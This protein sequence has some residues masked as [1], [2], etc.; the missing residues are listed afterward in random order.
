MRR[1]A[2]GGSAAALGFATAV[3][4]TVGAYPYLINPIVLFACQLLFTAWFIVVGWKLFRTDGEGPE[5]ERGPAIKR[6]QP[7]AHGETMTRRG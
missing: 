1:A 5:I 7:A 3:G 6:L 4:D 2:F